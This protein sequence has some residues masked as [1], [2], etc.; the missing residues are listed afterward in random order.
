MQAVQTGGALKEVTS[1]TE[2][3]YDF[4]LNFITN[5]NENMTINLPH[6]DDTATG[7]D[8]ADAMTAIINSGIVISARG[9][10]VLRHSA[11]VVRTE[12]RD[13]NLVG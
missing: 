8:V 10:P 13:F 12:R 9:E 11:E 7:T 1:L 3:R 4:R 6:A 5:N 2:T